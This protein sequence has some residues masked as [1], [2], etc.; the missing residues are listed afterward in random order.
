M[1]LHQLAPLG[2]GHS[3]EN[4]EE[5]KTDPTGFNSRS[6]G[7]ANTC[8]ASSWQLGGADL[9]A[10]PAA[11]KLPMRR[12]TIAKRANRHLPNVPAHK[13]TTRKRETWKRS[14]AQSRNHA[15]PRN[16]GKTS[17]GLV[18]AGLDPARHRRL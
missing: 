17:E 16:A 11:A 6:A 15:Y 7:A 8:P 4:G 3:T 9:A 10:R 18:H 12:H 2:S 14:N 13:C 1:P 5:A